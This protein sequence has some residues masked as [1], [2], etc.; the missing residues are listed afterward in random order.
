ME[1]LSDI[2]TD[3]LADQTLYINKDKIELNVSK[4]SQI[5]E[6]KLDIKFTDNTNKT[7]QFKILN[8]KL[9]GDIQNK[10]S[11]E[12]IIKISLIAGGSDVIASSTIS[13]VHFEALFICGIEDIMMSEI[14]KIGKDY[15]AII[16]KE[17]DE[18]RVLLNLYKF[19][20][21]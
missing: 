15:Y 10:G 20:T 6:H 13:N 17:N 1:K 14:R 5:E 7:N 21:Q 12:P 16:P 9:T 2:I 19:D 8:I 3:R 11:N 18:Y 4:V